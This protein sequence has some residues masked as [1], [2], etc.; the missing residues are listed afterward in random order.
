M[1]QTPN[2]RGICVSNTMVA[3]LSGRTLNAYVLLSYLRGR[4][5]VLLNCLYGTT[6][7]RSLMLSALT[8]Q[9]FC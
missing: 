1:D 5:V 6:A 4:A 8:K 3:P 2:R 9:L 7:V